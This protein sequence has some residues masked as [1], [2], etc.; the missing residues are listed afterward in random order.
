MELNCHGGN[1][2]KQALTD[3]ICKTIKNPETQIQQFPPTEP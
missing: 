3:R 2:N 1:K